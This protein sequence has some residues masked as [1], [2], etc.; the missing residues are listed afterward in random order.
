MNMVDQFE[1]AQHD[2]ATAQGAV[3][4]YASAAGHTNTARQGAVL[5]NSHVV[6]DLNQVVELDAVFDH[7]VAQSTPVN[8]GVRAN[9]NVIANAHRAELFD[10]FPDTRV[11]GETKT[12]CTNNHAWVQQTT[13][14]ERAAFAHCDSGLQL[15]ASTDA[16]SSLN[17]TERANAGCRVDLG[18][19][20]DHC[21]GV[22]PG[23]TRLA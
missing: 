4:A 1:V 23:G 3:S 12:V 21:A 17:H 19:G 11:R 5:A 15:A 22:Y 10:F 18:L 6:P 13:L 20:I 7:R 2:G 16:H 14:A 8:A 9:F